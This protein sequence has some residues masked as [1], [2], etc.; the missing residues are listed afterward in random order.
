MK[1]PSQINPALISAFR[2]FA[3]VMLL[4]SLFP[5]ILQL[6]GVPAR[7]SRFLGN[8]YVI[9][10]E[11]IILLI[12]LSIPWIAEKLGRLYLPIAIG[13]ATLAPVISNFL[14]LDFSQ[15]DELAQTRS[16]A[17][18]WEV[19]FL[20]FVP[21]ILVSWQYGFKIVV[22]YCLALAVLDLVTI[23]QI[24]VPGLIEVPR[25]PVGGA[26]VF[27]GS[28]VIRSWLLIGPTLLRTAVYLLV[29]FVVARLVA[30]QREQTNRLQQAYHQLATYATT[31]EQLTL[32][33]E[34]NRLA[35]ELHDTLAHTLSA[36]AVQLEAI[37]SL[38]ETDR[39]KASEI[40]ALSLKLTRDGLNETRRAIQSLRAA[41]VED[42]GLVMALSTLARSVAER[43]H[44]VIDL[45][46]PK[47]IKGWNPE[48]EHTF[49]RITEEGLRNVAQHAGAQKIAVSLQENGNRLSL[50][51]HDDGRGFDLEHIDPEQRFGLQ[52]MRE[53]AESIGARFIVNTA[54][55][56][57]T[58]IQ[59]EVENHHT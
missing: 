29:G 25:P 52:G 54:P 59:V 26:A 16:L 9:L 40:L 51:I 55:N 17:G 38:W 14:V 50:S 34:R 15:V 5:L 24:P 28:T 31:N 20:L 43:N 22:F 36:V 21:L 12:F 10:V 19:I 3:A 44:F 13:I 46:L 4:V 8:P 53:R 18:Q 2:V 32:S 45:S 49:Y 7:F 6:T 35:R 39:D 37:T 58:T 23:L 41:P 11:A 57:G 33:R 48:I 42:L 47:E 56:Q 30:G 27:P 1:N